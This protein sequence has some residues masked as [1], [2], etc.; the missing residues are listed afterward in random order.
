MLS[1]QEEEQERCETLENDKLV[2]EAEH[3]RIQREGTTM[4]QH[5]Q[6]A[7]NDEAGGRFASVNPTTVIG[8]QP[9]PTYPQLPANSPWH[10]SDPV[11]DEPPLGYRIDAVPEQEPSMA[12]GGLPSIEATGPA[13][14]DAPS[15]SDLASLGDAQ[16]AGA[17]PSSS[18]TETRLGGP[19]A[20]SFASRPDTF[21]PNV[22]AGSPSSN[23]DDDNG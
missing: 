14:A 19:A 9:L 8:V 17:G 12:V 4:H 1:R 3:R 18:Q 5:A 23:R 7:A 2:R 13:S 22:N 6:S 11:P 16:R 15:L 20:V 21:I 10:G